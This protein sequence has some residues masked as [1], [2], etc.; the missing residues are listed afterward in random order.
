MEEAAETYSISNTDSVMTIWKPR[1]E[2]NGWMDGW[3]G[4]L[5]MRAGGD[6]SCILDWVCDEGR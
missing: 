6:W 1:T 4:E 5:H 2:G 3:R